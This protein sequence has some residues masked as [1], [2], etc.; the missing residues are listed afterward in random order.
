[1]MTRD[2][3]GNI[4]FLNGENL[5]A[6]HN[7]GVLKRTILGL[8]FAASTIWATPE[9]GRKTGKECNY[10][11]PPNNFQLN[12]AGKYYQEHHKSLKGYV[13]KPDQNAKGTTKP[14]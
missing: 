7:G 14:K 5:I 10:C 2:N 12:E 1:M 3:A 8:L 4:G 11:H 6:C 9:Y 13:P